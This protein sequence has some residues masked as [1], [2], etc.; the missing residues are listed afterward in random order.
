VRGFSRVLKPNA[1]LTP[2]P[3]DLGGLWR[4]NRPSALSGLNSKTTL[5]TLVDCHP[6]AW[7]SEGQGLFAFPAPTSP[8][9][10]LTLRVAP[11]I[12]IPV[13]GYCELG[14]TR[15]DSNL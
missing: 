1:V 11:G 3:V 7:Q 10:R 15:V 9:A 6:Y 2:Y 8:V 4:I 13:F 5:W 12:S 14:S